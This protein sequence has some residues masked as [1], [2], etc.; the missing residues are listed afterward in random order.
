MNTLKFKTNIKCTGCI[1]K[2]SPILNEKLGEDQWDV[3]LMNLKKT[4]TVTTSVLNEA[5]VIEI[6]KESGFTAEPLD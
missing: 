1:S 4:L 5:E 3:D 6:V 2:A